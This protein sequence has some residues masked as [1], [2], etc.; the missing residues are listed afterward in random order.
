MT[1]ADY[2]TKIV[3]LIEEFQGWISGIILGL[4]ILAAIFQVVKYV[5]GDE[6]EQASAINRGKK[7]VY[8]L[9]VGQ[10]ITWLL[11][12]VYNFFKS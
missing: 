8:A 11:P 6:S 10:A 12:Y 9:I 7:L 4:V 1:G 3:T 2:F 5:Q